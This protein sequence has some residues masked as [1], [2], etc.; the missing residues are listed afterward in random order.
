MGDKRRRQLASANIRKRRR[1]S[2]T[3]GVTAGSMGR[4]QT[5]NPSQ[6]NFNS[7]A[8]T[9]NNDSSSYLHG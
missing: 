9:T 1:D 3:G 6:V 8:Y 2:G 7:N 5:N 4:P